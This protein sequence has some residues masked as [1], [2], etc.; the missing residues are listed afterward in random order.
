MSQW[1]FA[2]TTHRYLLPAVQ[3]LLTTQVKQDMSHLSLGDDTCYEAG[4]YEGTSLLEPCHVC[5][6]T[7]PFRRLW[8][9]D[10]G[11]Q[12]HYSIFLGASIQHLPVTINSLNPFLS[13]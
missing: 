8:L 4:G 13:G 2:T 7:V 1:D 9:G 6:R 3:S 12:R 5:L 11:S 10:L